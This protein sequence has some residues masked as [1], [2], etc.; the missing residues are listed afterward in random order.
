[1]SGLVALVGSGEFTAAMEKVDAGLLRAVGAD[2]PRVAIVPTASS[3]DGERT[4]QR[5]AAMGV[6]HFGAL[7]ADAEPVLIR[8][9]DGAFDEGHVRTLAGADLV[10]LS[11]GKPDHLLR[12]LR[13]T[14]AWEATLDVRARG[15]AI[16][17]CSAGAMVMAGCQLEARR[18]KLPLP[19][20]WTPGLGVVERVSV[21]P[22]YDRFPEP[23]A[24]LVAFGAP[25][26]VAVLGIDEDTAIVGRDG[27][28]QVQ[29]R[30]RVTV[31]RGR[32][33][34]RHRAG[35]VLRL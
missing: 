8:D 17:G 9:R 26:G 27:I 33:R 15:G 16:A 19:P 30:G 32:E 31:W 1:M 28:W 12:V 21:I 7:G 23:L 25:H 20:R 3:P 11:G 10:Y 29:G 35:D 5:W 14:P 24:A 18:G 4:F 34:R 6:D 2:R 22:H 13:D